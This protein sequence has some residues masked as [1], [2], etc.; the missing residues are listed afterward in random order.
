MCV[1]VSE[2]QKSQQVCGSV[3]GLQVSQQVCDCVSEH[4]VTQQVWGSEGVWDPGESGGVWVV[5]LSSS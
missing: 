3:P 4:Q 5:Y 1:G 2:L